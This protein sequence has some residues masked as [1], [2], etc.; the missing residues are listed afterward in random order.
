MAY[1]LSP[2]VLVQE[3]DLTTIVPSVATSIG[4]F[5]GKFSWGP[6]NEIHSITNEVE[7]VNFFGKPT[8]DNYEYWFSAANFLAYSN[9]LK[10][11]RTA[12]TDTKNA[13]SSGGGA[14]I[15]NTFVYE[16]QYDAGAN[17]YGMFAAKCAGEL[18]NTLKVYVADANT[19]SN[20]WT[21]YG[22]FTDAP[23]TSDYVSGQGGAN[24]E[25]HIVVVD[26]L[27]KFSNGAANTILERFA[28]VSKASDALTIGGATNYYKN[29]LNQRSQYLWSLSHPIGS[30]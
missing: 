30:N 24:D 5:A 1:L 28:F 26:T 19:Y 29:V 3:I 21:Y 10:L 23:A 11:I 16:T 14:L 27:G 15:E 7:L 22:Q 8:A 9:N 4:A 12:N 6:I 25:I 13:T 20:S 2:G 17:T 18:G